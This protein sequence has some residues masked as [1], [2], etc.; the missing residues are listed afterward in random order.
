MANREV[1]EMTH[2]LD[3]L[4]RITLLLLQTVQV[5]AIKAFEICIEQKR[6]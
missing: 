3:S 5:L 1:K 4:S 2:Q 6:E